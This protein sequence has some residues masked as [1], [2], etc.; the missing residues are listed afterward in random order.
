V[1]SISRS[2]DTPPQ[3]GRAQTGIAK[4]EGQPRVI[5]FR[6]RGRINGAQS[7]DR[8]AVHNGQTMLLR[9][10][11]TCG[12]F[13]SIIPGRATCGEGV[14]IGIDPIGSGWTDQGRA[15]S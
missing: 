5:V 10:F 6:V 12:R 1:T 2:H 13:T 9:I 15:G 8:T 11:D 3:S 4:S 7:D 14:A